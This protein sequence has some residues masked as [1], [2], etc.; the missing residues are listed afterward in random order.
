MSDIKKVNKLNELKVAFIADGVKNF[1]KSDIFHDSSFALMLAAQELDKKNVKILLTESN[2]LKII[3][4]KVF[5]KFDE[6]SLKK[7]ESN[8]LQVKS[9][10]EYALDTLDIIFARKDPPI[11]ES[12]LSYILMLSLVPHIG[13]GSPENDFKTLIVNNPLGILKANEKLYALNFPALIPHTL[14]TS[15]KNEILDFLNE[16]KEAVIKPLYDKGGGGVFYLSKNMNNVQSII[17]IST[18]D[19]TKVAMVQKYIPEVIKGDKRIILL[20][21]NPIGAIL[22]IPKVGEFRA[23]MNRGASVE[24]CELNKRDLEICETIKPHLQKDG[25]YFTGID[26]I[27]NYLTEINV[28]S[29]TG[30]QE[31]E[32]FTGRSLAKE[33][34]DWAIETACDH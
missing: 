8:H 11:N 1:S 26:V 27:G 24:H 20:N 2:N 29:P 25:L 18:Q 10:N 19:G 31:I 5:A 33:I 4:N 7:E 9:T 14:V 17:E 13:N 16:H 6:V 32:R 22:R 34:I 30:L 28:T 23:N 3:N 12:Y 15:R 21:G